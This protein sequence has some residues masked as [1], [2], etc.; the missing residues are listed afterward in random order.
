MDLQEYDYADYGEEDY[1]SYDPMEGLYDQRG[2][3]MMDDGG[4]ANKVY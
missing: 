4:R 3:V 1:E 2:F